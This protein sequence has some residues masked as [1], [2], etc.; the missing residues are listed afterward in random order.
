MGENQKAECHVASFHLFLFFYFFICDWR[1]ADRVFLAYPSLYAF[2]FQVKA[3]DV[4]SQVWCTTVGEISSLGSKQLFEKP[5][6]LSILDTFCVCV[7]GGIFFT[8]AVS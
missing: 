5:C 7:S 8:L 1:W 3:Q 4:A 2:S 6:G